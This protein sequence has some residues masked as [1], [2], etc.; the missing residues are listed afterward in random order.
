MLFTDISWRQSLRSVARYGYTSGMT[1][2][3]TADITAQ[4]PSEIDAQWAEI[5]GRA[6]AVR[7]HIE[8]NLERIER[9]DQSI[10]SGR[11]MASQVDRMLA[12][13]AAKAAAAGVSNPDGSGS[14]TGH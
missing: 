12:A 8:A 5:N 13:R 4:T 2:T 7:A 9:N 11:Y 14:S 6:A 1:T 3:A 10:A